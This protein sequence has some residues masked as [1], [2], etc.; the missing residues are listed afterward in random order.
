MIAIDTHQPAEALPRATASAQ[1][2]AS[3][4]AAPAPTSR[5]MPA[6]NNPDSPRS[7][8]NSSGSRRSS[9]ISPDI[10]RAV[11]AIFSA[12]ASI[13]IRCGPVGSSRS[14]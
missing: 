8:T 7:A 9:S 1:P 4:A 2:R 13:S 11:N 10:S 3:P 5:G 6:R 14:R 12:M